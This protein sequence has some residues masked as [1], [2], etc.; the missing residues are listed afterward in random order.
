MSGFKKDEFNPMIR[1]QLRVVLCTEKG[2]GHSRKRYDGGKE[3]TRS[4]E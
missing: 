4:S 3:S 1:G 2:Y